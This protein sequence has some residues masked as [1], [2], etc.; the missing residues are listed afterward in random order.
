M[1]VVLVNTCISLSKLACL[2]GL[3]SQN[4]ALP[5]TRRC[6]TAESREQR[7]L[8]VVPENKRQVDFARLIA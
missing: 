2:D 4:T 7:G 6:Q 3:K 1:G 5:C 8:S